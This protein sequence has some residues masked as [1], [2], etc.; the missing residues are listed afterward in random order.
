MTQ[1]AM[2]SDYF[3]PAAQH[4]EKIAFANA[5]P[6]VM[7]LTF[8]DR[9]VAPAGESK[10]DWQIF[11][12]LLAEVAAVAERRGL[13]EYTDPEGR[14]RRYGELVSAYTMNGYYHDQDTIADE[15][16]RDSALA[17]TI[18]ADTTLET[19]RRTGHVRYV[20]WGMMPGALAQASPFET[21]RTHAPFRNHVEKGAPFPS[22]SRRA[23]FYI[24]H[25]WFLEAG[26][27]LPVHKPNPDMGG[28]Y[29]LGLTSGH[30]RWSVHSM[31]HMNE[32]VLGTHRGE[33]NVMV[34]ADDARARS[35]EDGELI[36]IF[37]DVG[38]FRARAKVA[39]N[40]MQGQI[41]SYNGWE[42]LQYESWSGANEIEPGLVKWIGF[43]GGYG[44]LNY[45]FLGWQPV[46]IDRWVRCDFER[47]ATT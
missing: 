18:P 33:P 7:N 28:E 3:L 21:D 46:P 8:S 24:D 31:N 5:G 11:T 12:E 29:P 38:E 43:A 20:D 14:V 41:V 13:T 22:Y 35:V 42:P 32:V 30:N 40:V 6:Y 1:T 15:M 4:Y 36:R 37:N 9:A 27:E 34:N 2:H 16:V 26:E 45:S 10:T 25:E 17:G 23:Q 39:P 47:D 44:H 19:M